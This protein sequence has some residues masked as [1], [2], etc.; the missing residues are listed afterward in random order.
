MKF[1]EKLWD[2][3]RAFSILIKKKQKKCNKKKK[4]T[5]Q[6]T[7]DKNQGLGS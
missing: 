5:L 2:R 1:L 4:I 7:D 6:S 3:K